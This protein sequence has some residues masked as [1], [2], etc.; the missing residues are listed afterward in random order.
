MCVHDQNMAF[1]VLFFHWKKIDGGWRPNFLEETK[2][3]REKD[4]KIL[5]VQKDLQDRRVEITGP[6]NQKMI[7]GITILNIFV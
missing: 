1:L 7:F 4:W 2:S 3:I 5:G 6:T